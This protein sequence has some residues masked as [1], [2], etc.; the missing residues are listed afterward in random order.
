MG[1]GLSLP[2]YP[3]TSIAATRYPAAASGGIWWRQ[4]Y[5]LSGQPCTSK[6][7]GPFPACATRSRMPLV[8]TRENSGFAFIDVSSGRTGCSGSNMMSLYAR[9]GFGRSLISDE[10]WFA[11]SSS[12]AASPVSGVSFN[13]SDCR[14]DGA[15]VLPEGEQ[16]GWLLFFATTP[17]VLVACTCFAVFNRECIEPWRDRVRG[18]FAGFARPVP[19]AL[20]GE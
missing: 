16:R 9:R 1:S 20:A 19:A 11:S 17:L 2:P 10:R 14:P 15:A 3:R 8:S 7:S 18:G 6:M 5:Q 13:R 12:S 4:E